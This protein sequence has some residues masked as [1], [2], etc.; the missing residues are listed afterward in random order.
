[1]PDF[2]WKVSVKNAAYLPVFTVVC[3]CNNYCNTCKNF[4]NFWKVILI[5]NGDLECLIQ[6]PFANI[7]ANIC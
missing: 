6:S 7:F 1:M 4:E 5:V 2:Q 3:Y